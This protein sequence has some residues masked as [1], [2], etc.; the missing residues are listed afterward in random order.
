MAAVFT[1]FTSIGVLA[2]L[3]DRPSMGDLVTWVDCETILLILSMMVLV[4]ILSDSGFFENVALY[5]L[6]VRID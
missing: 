3:H 1:A 4:A 5:S 6:H 2:A